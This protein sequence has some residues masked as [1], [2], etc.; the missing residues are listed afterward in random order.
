[1]RRGQ[2]VLDD[3]AQDDRI[4]ADLGDT[5]VSG[6]YM[7]LKRKKTNGRSIW[8]ILIRRNKVTEYVETKDIKELIKL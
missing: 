5:Y 4:K 7:G 3:L 8:F 6:S 1:M 2:R